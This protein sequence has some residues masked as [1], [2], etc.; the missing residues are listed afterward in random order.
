MTT[1]LVASLLLHGG[2]ALTGP[3]ILVNMANGRSFT[4]QTDA[5]NA[6]KSVAGIVALVKKGFYDGTRVHRVVPGF[7]VQWGDPYSRNGVDDPRVG[8]GGSGKDLPFEPGK[9]SFKTGVLGVA[10]KGAGTG[11]DG[12]IFVMT[13]DAPQLDGGYAA[14]GKVVSGLK[15]VLAIQKGDKVLS[16]RIVK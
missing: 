2:Q 3:K 5:K 10:S 7:C 1:L 4:I 6:P 16:M 9:L 11:G 14:I 15:V 8:T 13:G 12:Q